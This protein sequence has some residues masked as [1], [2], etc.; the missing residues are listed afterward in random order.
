MKKTKKTKTKTKTKKKKTSKF[1]NG[2]RQAILQLKT[3]LL[4]RCEREKNPG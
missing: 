2:S 4:T 3:I 1:C